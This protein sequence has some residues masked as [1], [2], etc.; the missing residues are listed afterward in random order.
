MNAAPSIVVI[1]DS[2][3]VCA[4]L[5]TCLHRAGYQVT[6]FADPLPALR[7]L[8]VTRE[9]AP[10]DLFLVDLGLRHMDG[11]TVIRRLR[12]SQEHVR[13]PIVVLSGRDGVLDRVK[14]RLAGASEYLTK[15]F[16]VQQV[17]DKLARLLSRA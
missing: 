14:A 4:I 3:T 8:F 17:T 15:P 5:E 6:S 2:A 1:D 12:N 9:I 7:A 11:Y 16:T 10:P 13:T